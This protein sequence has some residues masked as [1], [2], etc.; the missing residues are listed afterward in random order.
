MLQSFAMNM[1]HHFSRKQQLNQ[2]ASRVI[3]KKMNYRTGNTCSL[4]WRVQMSW[5]RPTRIVLIESRTEK[6]VCNHTFACC[7]LYDWHKAQVVVG[8]KC[9]TQT[10]SNFLL[11]EQAATEH[12]TFLKVS[13]KLLRQADI[14][15]WWTSFQGC[16]ILQ[17][18]T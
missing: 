15:K 1:Q 13:T 14:R 5:F 12:L 11:K 4:K 3:T 7:I 9:F 16:L 8:K 10:N 2:K 17:Q 6:E 18:R